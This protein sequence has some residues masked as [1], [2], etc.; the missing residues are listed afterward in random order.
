MGVFFAEPL[1]LFFL[2]MHT[3]LQDMLVS[4]LR[5]NITLPPQDGSL[6]GPD[7]VLSSLHR[8]VAFSP[9]Q[10]RKICA[11]LRQIGSIFPQVGGKMKKYL[12]QPTS[13]FTG[14]DLL[15]QTACRY[16][17]ASS[18]TVAAAEVVLLCRGSTIL[19]SHVLACESK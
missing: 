1:S 8:L 4:L 17:Q 12:K 11:F 18:L 2:F 7:L 15:V 14:A 10:N 6:V 3:A 19:E 5:Y 13:S 16:S 9:T